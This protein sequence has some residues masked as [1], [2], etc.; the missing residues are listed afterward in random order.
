M[1]KDN[2]YL[3]IL[4]LDYD[5]DPS[6]GKVAAKVVNTDRFDKMY[7][8]EFC[9]AFPKEISTEIE[10]DNHNSKNET[11]IIRGGYELVSSKDRAL[12]LFSDYLINDIIDNIT[13]YRRN[14]TRNK[15]ECQ[16]IIDQSFGENHVNETMQFYKDAI[17]KI[18]SRSWMINYFREP[19][20][21][22]AGVNNKIKNHDPLLHC[23]KII[24]Q[25]ASFR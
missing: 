11:M 7:F 16:I 1:E 3:I 23:E 20:L 17:Q 14:L 13:R 9:K 6:Y 5:S 19:A 21:I 25:A 10:L 24:S 22:A 2:S 12:L 15:D 8:A 18:S 4:S